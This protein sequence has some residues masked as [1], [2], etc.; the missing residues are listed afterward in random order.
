M[1]LDG[2]RSADGDEDVG[3]SDR[4]QAAHD[5]IM[6][7]GGNIDERGRMPAMD[8]YGVEYEDDSGGFDDGESYDDSQELKNRL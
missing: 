8:D 6:Q 5:R 4:Q 2:L 7:L 1:H 3:L